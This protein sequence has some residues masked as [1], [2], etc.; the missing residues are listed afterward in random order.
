MG[1][2][3][4]RMGRVCRHWSRAATRFRDGGVKG[5]LSYYRCVFRQRLSSKIA[6]RHWEMFYGELQIKAGTESRAGSFLRHT[7]KSGD[8]ELEKEKMT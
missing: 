6:V 5:K 1:V 4:V 8:R 2:Y 3:L 7:R